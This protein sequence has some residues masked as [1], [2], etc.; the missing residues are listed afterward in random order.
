M[1]QLNEFELEVLEHLP[2]EPTGLSLAELADGLLDE[3]GPMAKG[4]VRR[5]LECIAKTLGRLHVRTGNDD[6][7]GF[8]VK[9]YGLPRHKMPAVR[10]FFAERQLANV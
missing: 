8:N 5:A 10:T 1:Q 2:V 6:L 4:K 3:R 9:M 7:G